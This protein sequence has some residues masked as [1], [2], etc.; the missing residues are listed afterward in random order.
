[1]AKAKRRRR[2]RR[3]P[4]EYQAPK[5]AEPASRPPAEPPRRHAARDE[6]PPAPWGSFPLQELTVLVGLALL[7]IGFVGSSPVTIAVG[8]ALG[9][10]AG[11]ELSVREHFAG[12]RSHSVLLAGTAFV[13]TVGALYYFGDLILLICLIAGAAVFALLLLALRAAFRR[14]SGGLS[15]KVG[16]L[17]G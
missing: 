17:R 10:L 15:F 9:C 12:Y 13:F 2:R 4:G 14:A 8:V 16:G 5:V 1:M 6:R 11:L 3:P 7:A